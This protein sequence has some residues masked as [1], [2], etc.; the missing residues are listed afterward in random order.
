[1]TE[2]RFNAMW[3]R[4]ALARATGIGDPDAVELAEA[5]RSARFALTLIGS[6]PISHQPAM[7][8][9][10]IESASRLARAVIEGTEKTEFPLVQKDWQGL[11]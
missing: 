2:E 7:P 8:Q 5:L 10:I 11:K 6:L 1:M 3:K 4:L 9:T